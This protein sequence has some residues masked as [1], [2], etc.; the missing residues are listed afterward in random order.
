M[1]G[2]WKWSALWS[3]RV[4]L[5]RI[6]VGVGEDSDSETGD[7]GTRSEN[8]QGWWDCRDIV[9]MLVVK[10]RGADK[11]I[12]LETRALRR[13]IEIDCCGTVQHLTCDQ[14]TGAVRRNGVYRRRNYICNDD[15]TNCTA[16]SGVPLVRVGKVEQPVLVAF[17]QVDG[18]MGR[19]VQVGMLSPGGTA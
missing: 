11:Y 17:R 6:L 1:V 7:N 9:L 4:V 16:A 10:D 13:I 3:G 19:Q 15:G 12:L 2:K 8:G 5:L 18:L 14:Q